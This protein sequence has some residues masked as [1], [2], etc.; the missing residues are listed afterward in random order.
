M[1]FH[2]L[3]PQTTVVPWMIE[4]SLRETEMWNTLM[5]MT[6]STLWTLVGASL[7]Q[8]SQATSRPTQ[9]LEQLLM[10]PK[11][12]GQGKGKKKST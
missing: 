9:M 2:S 3:K 11:G 4:V 12:K 10:G 5:G 7:K 6:Q 8:H 1:R